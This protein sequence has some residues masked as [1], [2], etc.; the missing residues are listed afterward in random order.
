LL[1]VNYNEGNIDREGRDGATKQGKHVTGPTSNM[2]FGE[3]IEWPFRESNL[4]MFTDTKNQNSDA[5][6]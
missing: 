4:M 6:K 2:V 5:V 3:V 1:F